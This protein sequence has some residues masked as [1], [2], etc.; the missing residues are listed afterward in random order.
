MGKRTSEGNRY[1]RPLMHIRLGFVDVVVATSASVAA[2]FLK[3]HDTDFL[4]QPPNTGAK[5][6]AYNYQDLVFVP[7]GPRWHMLRKTSYIH[8]FSGKVLDK[9]RYLRRWVSHACMHASQETEGAMMTTAQASPLQPPARGWRWRLLRISRSSPRCFT[10]R[11][12]AVLESWKSFLIILQDEKDADSL[13]VQL[14]DE[15]ERYILRY[16]SFH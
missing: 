14:V 11:N 13:Y 3:V 7:Y 4:S 1:H 8:L 15:F 9:F 12:P 5:Y 10:G 16:F 6:I 2:Q